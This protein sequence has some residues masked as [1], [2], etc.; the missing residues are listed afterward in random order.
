[1]HS[2]N[3]R[4]GLGLAAAMTLAA[5][6]LVAPTGAAAP[7]DPNGSTIDPDAATTLTVHKCEQTD[8]NGV[9]EGTGN[10]DPQAECK[11]VSDVE[12]T[13]T[14]LNVDLTT[15]DGWKTLADLKGDVVKAGA[16]KSNT[17]QKITTGANGL[18]S[19]TDAQTEVG[20]YLISE[21]RAPDKVIP[22]EDFVV[23]LP[24]TNPQDTAKWNYNVHVY[25][26]N[27]L[28]GVDK[29]VTD[30]PAPGS[31]RD[32]TYTITTSI[33]KV[34]YPG[35]ARI[36]R[37][38]VVD[39]LDKRIKKEALAPVVKI[40]GQNEVTLANGT[41]YNLITADGTDHNWATIQLTEK[42]LSKASEERYNGTGETKLQVTLTAKFDADVNLEGELSNTAG[43]I[44]ND[45][46]NFTWDPNRPGTKVPGIPTTPVL[47]KYGK[48]ILTKTGT[49][50]LADK[51]KYNG[52]QFQV[53][54]C[55]KTAT[56]ATLHDSD[57][58]T[59]AVVDPLTIGGQ[60]TFTTTGQGKVEINYLRANDYV[61]GA[62]KSK[63][64]L[65]NDDYYCLVETKAPEGYSL[66]ADPI[67]FRVLAADAEA[68]APTNLTVTDI[69]K[70]AGFRLP[71]TGANGVIFLTV[72]GA[73]LVAGG[74]VVAYANK[75][76]HVAKH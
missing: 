8:T 59:P 67:P 11:P 21:T 70:N 68:K 71:L 23:T 17:V 18:A 37:Y 29:Q 74:A 64:Q 65:T 55:T 49:D 63:E 13:I 15:Y 72:A 2:L 47:S 35:G 54:E 36:K 34:D 33:P 30:K 48:V 41:D 62:A 19:F 43:L 52:A 7:A 4:R 32:I 60:K 38:E 42:G 16:L 31:G 26:K 73:L 75:R 50:D 61:N 45:S 44:P 24:M 22:A 12:F 5:G 10:E 9:K 40:V 28:S 58:S 6:V 25:P 53:Y 69:P 57:P 46:P 56:G 51:T 20:A 1:M 66:Q 76:R 14:K 39:Q 27:T 3:T